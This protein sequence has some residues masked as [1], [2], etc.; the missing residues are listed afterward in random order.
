MQFN[1]KK[2]VYSLGVT[3]MLSTAIPVVS[4]AEE[5]TPQVSSWATE[6]LVQG[7]KYGIFPM[8]WYSKDFQ[9]NISLKRLDELMQLTEEK[10]AALNLPKNE[11][12]VPVR[13]RKNN[14]R[15]NII[16]RLYNIVGQYDLNVG[17]DPVA[18]MQDR[19]VL[20]GSANG[21]KLKARATT[22]EA[23]IF[24]VRLVEDTYKQ[25]DA[26]GKG[27][28]WVVEDEDT[29]VYLLGS[30]HMGIPDLYP[31]HHKLISAF[32]ESDALFVEVNLLEDSTNLVLE[33]AFYNDGRTIRDDLSDEAYA[34]LVQVAEQMY[35]PMEVLEGIKPWSLASTLSSL[36]MDGHYGNLTG[37][38]MT[39]YGVDMQF[40]LQATVQQKPIYELEGIEKQLTMFDSLSKETQEEM[41]VSLL[42]EILT[43]QEPDENQEDILADWFEYWRLGDIENFAISAAILEGDDEYSKMLFGQRDEDMASSLIELLETE[44]GEFFVVVGAGHF[45]VENNI[46]THLEANN[47][48]V[49]PFYE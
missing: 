49:S 40:L 26:G 25:V 8:D 2:S 27:V 48:K 28:A 24:A 46:R 22:E 9:K 31:M 11:K 10:I 21:L 32:N 3:L 6:T 38:E 14:T 29:K 13:E 43:P 30:I 5:A 15:E 37:V 23:V 20:R 16:N 34:K 35:L 36:L 1:F 33:K 18:Y 4:S 39:Q 42:D 41:L 12:F 19:N 47:Y 17:T 44:P 7:E 45:L